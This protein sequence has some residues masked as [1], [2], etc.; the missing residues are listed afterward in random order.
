[1]WCPIDLLIFYFFLNHEDLQK[2]PQPLYNLSLVSVWIPM[3]THWSS[4]YCCWH[5]DSIL[6][7]GL[8]L[9][10]MNWTVVAACM[11]MIRKDL[12]Q[13]VYFLPG[14]TSVI[15]RRLPPMKLFAVI[16]IDLYICVASCNWFVRMGITYSHVLTAVFAP[17]VFYFLLLFSQL[18]LTNHVSS[19][20]TGCWQGSRCIYSCCSA[21]SRKW[22]SLE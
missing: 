19:T 11:C 2:N 1:M 6:V 7:L 4:Y 8:L 13:M 10:L 15:V 16:N 17:F 22:G 5:N 9:T 3:N 21:R 20:G 18:L 12:V 14:V